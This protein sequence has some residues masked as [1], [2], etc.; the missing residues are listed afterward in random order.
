MLRLKRPGGPCGIYQTP[1]RIIA[2]NVD[3]SSKLTVR[4]GCRLVYQTVNPTP[5]LLIV[6][7]RS[8]ETQLIASESLSISPYSAYEEVRD[9]MGNTIERWELSPGQTTITNDALIEVP[10]AADDFNRRTNSVF[11]RQ[12]P[13][14]VLRYLLPSRYCDSD[15]SDGSLMGWIVSLR[16]P[17]GSTTTSGM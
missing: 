10:T 16:F 15:N 6:R 8:S 11:V 17:T 3:L 1:S 13:A 4:I 2:V 5:I 9:W 12:L 7:P 14:S